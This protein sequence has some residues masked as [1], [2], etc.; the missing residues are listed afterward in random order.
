[1]VNRINA[2]RTHFQIT[3]AGPGVLQST[4]DPASGV[5]E[6]VTMNLIWDDALDSSVTYYEQ[7]APGGAVELWTM[8]DGV[9]VPPWAPE[10]QARIVDWLL[11]HPK[12]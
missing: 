3:F 8:Q 7:T 4:T 9:P 12:P 11:A 5:W 1:M 6:F 2:G 10:C